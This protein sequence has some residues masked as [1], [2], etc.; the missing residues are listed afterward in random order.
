MP[1]FNRGIDRGGRIES[2]HKC[3]QIKIELKP[4]WIILHSRLRENWVN[5]FVAWQSTSFAFIF[6]VLSVNA[7]HSI[8]YIPPVSC[9]K[10]QKLSQHSTLHQM[11]IY[12][13]KQSSIW[14]SKSILLTDWH[15]V[16]WARAMRKMTRR[17]TSVILIEF[18]CTLCDPKDQLLFSLIHSTLL[19]CVLEMHS[20]VLSI[21]GCKRQLKLARENTSYELILIIMFHVQS[22][23]RT[24]LECGKLVQLTL[25]NFDDSFDPKD[26]VRLSFS[27]I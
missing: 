8:K 12:K 23:T 18:Y 15:E 21:F 5:L 2:C 7:G 4:F 16:Q 24:C 13:C 14:I 1:A 3:L 20:D 17:Q 19:C 9:L 10:T 6:S 22:A 27:L 11:S 26:K 25:I